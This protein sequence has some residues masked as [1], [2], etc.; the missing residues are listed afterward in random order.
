MHY[1]LEVLDFILSDILQKPAFLLAIISAVGYTILKKSKTIIIKGAIKTAVGYIMMNAGAGILVNGFT[2]IVSM[3]SKTYN[4]HGAILGPYVQWVNALDVMRQDFSWVTYIVLLGLSLNIILVIFN[5]WTGI[6]VIFLT[7]Q[8]LF[9]EAAILALFFFLAGCS[10]FETIAFSSIIAGLYWA[11]SSNMIY[12]PTQKVTGGAGFS[13]G[14][15]QQFSSYVA[16]KSAPYL[17]NPKDSVENMKLPSWLHIFNDNVSAITIVMTIFLGAILLSLGIKNI[18]ILSHGQN[19]F[20]YILYT[21]L[22]FA[23]SIQIIINGVRMFVSELTESFKGISEKLIPNAV[24]GIDVAAIFGFAPNSM[25]FGFICGAIGQLVAVGVMISLGSAILVVPGFI[26]L[27]FSN[28]AIGCYANK[29]GGWKAAAIICFIAG[30]LEIFGSAYGIYVFSHLNH[31]VI[32]SWIG[33]T[34]FAVFFPPV[35]KALSMSMWFIIV[36]IILAVIYMLYAGKDHR[37]RLVKASK[38]GLDSV[39]EL[40]S[41][42]DEVLV[43]G[44]DTNNNQEATQEQTQEVQQTQNSDK[45]IRILTVCGNGQGSSM[46]MR[47]KIADYLNKKGIPNTTDSCAVS[48]YKS[49]LGSTDIIV[50]STHLAN[51]IEVSDGVDKLGVKNMLNPNTFGAEL[52]ALIEKHRS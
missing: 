9:Q 10:M 30:L 27:F 41:W 24:I 28:A 8:I 39:D 26:P 51:D 46:I 25:V 2:P 3:L 33:M 31:A 35:F 44:S 42:S 52:L 4:I 15:M 12:R 18:E 20:I 21:G 37:A 45:P 32:N 7:G 47:M 29:F 17:G 6:R 43:K 34:D 23:V 13:I 16:A 5:K 49:H 19:W 22:M 38:L 40:D 1:V 36:I 48:E 11:I 50:S 14:H